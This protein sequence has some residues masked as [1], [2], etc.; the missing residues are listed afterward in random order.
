MDE[1]VTHSGN[2]GADFIFHFM[3][4]VMGMLDGHL[5]VH[6]DVHIGVELVTHLA[7]E[8]FFHA[9]DAFD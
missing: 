4:N 7:H 2:L 3:G 1:D 9:V 6:F 5:R 8:A